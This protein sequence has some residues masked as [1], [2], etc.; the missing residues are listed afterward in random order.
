MTT[1]QQLLGADGLCLLDGVDDP[2]VANALHLRMNSWAAPKRVSVSALFSEMMGVTAPYLAL[3]RSSA[4]SPDHMY[5]MSR[6]KRTPHVPVPC[7]DS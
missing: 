7:S 2:P 3:P 1:I 5:K 4:G 6:R